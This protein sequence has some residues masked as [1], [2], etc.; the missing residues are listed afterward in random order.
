MDL[1]QT[2]PACHDAEE[3]VAEDAWRAAQEQPPAERQLSNDKLDRLLALVDEVTEEL[4][5]GGPGDRRVCRLDAITLLMATFE[6][7]RDAQ[8]G[9]SPLMYLLQ[10][11]RQKAAAAL[12]RHDAQAPALTYMKV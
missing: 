5:R 1:A 8:P 4:M 2:H 7:L 11:E 10:E 12:G 6:R 9:E 3:R